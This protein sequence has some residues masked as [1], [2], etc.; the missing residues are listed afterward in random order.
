MSQRL[1]DGL[2]REAEIIRCLNERHPNEII[3]ELYDQGWFQ[4]GDVEHPYLV[5][6]YVD[7][8]NLKTF[9]KRRGPLPT[10]EALGVSRAVARGLA[11]IHAEG[12]VHGDVSPENLIYLDKVEPGR[13]NESRYRLIDFGDAQKFEFDGRAD[14]I[15]GKPSFI[16]PEQASGFPA[17]PASDVYSL[18]M[19]LFFL[20]V[21]RPAFESHNSMD[22]LKMQRESELVLPPQLRPDIALIIYMMCSKLPLERPDAASV[23]KFLNEFLNA[24]GDS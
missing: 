12:F 6:E 21:G 14:E 4:D 2:V 18:G 13:S 5:L 11:A 19:V 23:V 10:R 17:T 1:Q 8:P 22:V 9:V 20:L 16:S 3:V 7:G 24:K 15:T